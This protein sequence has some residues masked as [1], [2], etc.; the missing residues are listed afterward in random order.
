MTRSENQ[1]GTLSLNCARS[2]LLAII[3][4]I[5]LPLTGCLVVGVR[6]APR[7]LVW[8]SVALGSTGTPKVVTVSNV[9][10]SQIAITS[11]GISGANAGDFAIASK[12]CGDSLA[13]SSSCTV[14]IIFTPQ[15][16]GTREATFT[17][18]HSGFNPSQSVSLS[19]T[20]TGK[21]S[22]L[23]VAPQAL[24]FSALDVGS[25]SAVQTVTLQSDGTTTISFDSVAIA[26]ADPGD[27]AIAGNTCGSS[28]GGSSNCSIGII[29]NP[30]AAGARS[31]TLTISDS[32]GGSPHQVTLSGTGNLPV[33]GGVTVSP[34][35]IS[36]PDTS[37]GSTSAAQTV[38]LSNSSAS[39][40]TL[41]AV[42]LSGTNAGD[43]A[44]ASN[45]CGASLAGAGNCA[46]G[47][48]FKPS[49]S[50]SRVST[51]SV[52]ASGTLLK[53]SLSGTATAS[54]AGGV[55]VSP[56]SVTFTDA[57]IDSTSS[58]KSVTLRNSGT[59]AITISSIAITGAN[60][61]DFTI[62]S[63]TC[64][65]TLIASSSCS[66]TMSF[67]PSASG[68]RTA[69][70]VFTDSAANSPQ[71]ATL[72]GS[73]NAGTT[74]SIA[75][76]NPTVLVNGT[77]QFSANES[78]T[79]TATCGTISKSGL[80]T[81]PSSAG[82]CTVTATGTGTTPPSASTSVN[83][84]SGS[85]S[86]TLTV[87]PSTAAVFAGTDQVFQAQL[88]SV[89]DANPVTYS[90]DGVPGGNA[91]AGVITSQGVYTAPNVAGSHVL[92][93]QDNTLGTAAT[94]KIT[95]FSDVNVDFDS[96]SPSLHAI[97]PDLF[98]T[99]RMDSLHNTADLDL[100]KAGGMR[101]ARFYAQIPFVFQT[102]STANW[103]A[104]DF[105]VQK[106]S[107]GGVHVMLQMVQT[108]PWL[109]PDPNPC[110]AGNSSAMPTDVNAWASL[111]TQ[112]VKHMDETFPGVVTDYEIW[113]EP[114]TVALCGLASARAGN[115]M[116]LYAAAAPMM[117]AQAAADAQAS[118]L[119]AARVGGPGT[120]GLQSGWVTEMLSDPIISQNIDFLSY[121][122]YL[123][124]NHQTGA[125]WDT[126]N[127]VYSV[128]QRTQD[129]GAGPMHSYVFAT[130]MVAA[131][132][133][134]Q[135]KNLPVYNTEYNLNWA[136]AKN[137]CANDPTL[138][139]VWNSMYAADMLNSVYNGAPD[140]PGHMV[141]FAATAVPYFCLVGQIDADMDCAY[142]NGSVPEPY[143][144]YYVYQLLGAT[145]YLDLQDGGFMAKS[146]SPGTLGNG[147]VVTA[148][149]TKSLDAIVIINPNQNTLSNVAVNLNNTG[150]ASAQG[151]LYQI[152]N[153][154]SIQSAPI[155][156]ENQ[157]G[158]SYTTTVTIGPYSVQAISIHN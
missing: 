39:A 152:L 147:L 2:F 51:L 149:Y 34:T 94:A 102:N 14:A 119:P 57:V 18:N 42:G 73:G 40:V 130:R 87:Y 118:G 135:G 96:R 113:N 131:G 45:S 114:N 55:S 37:A 52:S 128:Y 109:Q 76:T 25:P 115:Y 79:W 48:V 88:S 20:T 158:T 97:S 26:G 24:S 103:Q 22:T 44:I 68:T 122:D 117:R 4:L 11:I 134:P 125:Q 41:S 137:C 99:E 112:Y 143:P 13:A 15:A 8:S 132:K 75:P 53:V 142:P 33:T 106:I 93:V 145:N 6:V 17:I 70:L 133:Q 21:I 146:I 108:P 29:F 124:T 138:S 28:L 95:V 12:T 141:Y 89:P 50:G 64:G 126:Y 19:G 85:T 49:S 58:P 67:K 84:S 91:T 35:S 154:Q 72:S 77:L 69:S 16:A 144:Q 116:K 155:T 46:I 120:A 54:N 66:V 105:I 36:F 104:I 5:L 92:T 32:A 111:A 157:T 123:F 27:F 59:S 148:F 129:S 23:T 81:A 127:G 82:S 10:T 56:A 30:T 136:F 38:T 86:G 121:H 65:S 110:G 31:A 61:S 150:L 1:R 78:V 47:V 43:F 153:G 101:Y 100:V 107:A 63:K 139:P 83:V 74:L 90:V 140:V 9:G 62:T 156:L 80:F 71:T 3:F 7:S 98:G 151:T 60:A